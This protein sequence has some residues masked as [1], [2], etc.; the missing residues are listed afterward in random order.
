MV[1]HCDSVLKDKFMSREVLLSSHRTKVKRQNL[2]VHEDVKAWGLDC[3]TA[4][5]KFSVCRSSF[6]ILLI[7]SQ[8]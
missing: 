7:T 1:T 6:L 2:K 3:Q 5:L 8:N 4:E